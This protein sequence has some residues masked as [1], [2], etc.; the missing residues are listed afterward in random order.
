VTSAAV[1]LL[2]LDPIELAVVQERAGRES[3]RFRSYATQWASMSPVELPAW[4]GALTEILG[5][6]HGSLDA[7]MFVA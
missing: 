6:H 5:E 2:G 4:G 3:D 1:R 7:R